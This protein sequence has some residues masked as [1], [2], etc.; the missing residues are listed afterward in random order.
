MNNDFILIR[1]VRLDE[2]EKISLLLK[3][4]YEQYEN[5]LPI[6]AWN[7]YLEDIMN[8]RSRLDES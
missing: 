3:E 8:V 7:H 4:A 6:D 5:M 1:D 2:L